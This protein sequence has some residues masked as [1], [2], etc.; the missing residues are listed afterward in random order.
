MSSFRLEELG[1]KAFQDLCGTIL[2]E[3]LGQTVQVFSQGAD[4]GRDGAFHTDWLVRNAED[5][6]SLGGAAVIQCKHFKSSAS[7]LMPSTVKEELAKIEALVKSGEC[8]NY[9]LMSNG[10]LSAGSETKIREQVLAK[11]AKSCL[12]F[13]REWIEATVLE[14]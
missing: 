7:S 13:G 4:A 3:V 2:R 9:V 10:K 1:W 5:S 11:G 12:I 8:Q 14:N 6:F